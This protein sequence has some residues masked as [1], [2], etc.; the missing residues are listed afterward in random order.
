MERSGFA[1]EVTEP[2]PARSDPEHA[3]TVFEYRRYQPDAEGSWV[4]RV[5]EVRSELLGSTVESVEAIGGSNPEGASS[6]F[7]KGINVTV[8]Q[9]I[10]QVR[11]GLEDSNRIPIVAIETVLRTKPHEPPAI[12]FDTPH[13][14]LR[15]PVLDLKMFEAKGLR[16]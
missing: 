16:L 13:R 8:A 5:M 3:V 2:A 12:L 14:R 10:R 6:V 7:M 1:I 15:E 4:F 11:H 9:L